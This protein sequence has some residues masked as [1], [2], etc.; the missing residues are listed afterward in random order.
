MKGMPV[1]VHFAKV[2]LILVTIAI[3]IVTAFAICGCTGEPSNPGGRA[4]ISSPD[5]GGSLYDLADGALGISQLPGGAGEAFQFRR[6]AKYTVFGCDLH[7]CWPFLQCVICISF[8]YVS[9]INIRFTNVN[10]NGNIFG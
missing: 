10:R 7:G 2:V 5:E 4:V 3:S 6:P 1:K 8:S 9:I